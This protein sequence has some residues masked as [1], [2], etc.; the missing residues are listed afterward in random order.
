MHCPLLRCD[1]A[2]PPRYA[3]HVAAQIDP[4]FA[5][6]GLRAQQQAL[7]VDRVRRVLEQQVRRLP[8]R[9]RGASSFCDAHG[10]LIPR[11]LP[12]QSHAAIAALHVATAREQAAGRGAGFEQEY[13]AADARG[14]HVAQGPAC[15]RR[16]RS[17]GW[18]ASLRP[19]TWPAAGWRCAGRRAP[20]PRSGRGIRVR[21]CAR[22]R[23]TRSRASPCHWTMRPRAIRR[24]RSSST[25]SVSA[26]CSG[27]KRDCFTK[28]SAITRIQ[29]S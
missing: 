20:P 23:G 9:W 1:A 11:Q 5:V 22:C 6:H 25:C 27:S 17:A 26:V 14:Q 3:R 8:A 7:A 12:D 24:D 13:V 16:D 18:P 2:M 4:A 21:R 19:G 10:R 28:A 29:A 15:A